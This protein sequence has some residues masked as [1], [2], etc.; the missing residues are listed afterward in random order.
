MPELLRQKVELALALRRELDAGVFDLLDDGEE[1]LNGV[2]EVLGAGPAEGGFFAYDNELFEELG[3][4]LAGE[5]VRHGHVGCEMGGYF[6][7][8]HPQW[9]WW[10][11]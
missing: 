8:S 9:W 11:N 3:G 6:G 4:Y 10:D 5:K 1:L 7:F 2:R